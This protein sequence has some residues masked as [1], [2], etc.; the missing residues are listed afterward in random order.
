MN[1]TYFRVRNFEKLQPKR[2]G[3]NAPWI[4]LY[5]NWMLDSAVSQLGDTAKAHWIGIISVAHTESNRIPYDPV[6]IKRR[7][8]FNS[9]VKLDVFIKLGL[10]EILDNKSVSTSEQ[11][12]PIGSIGRVEEK[13]VVIQDENI[14]VSD[15]DTLIQHYRKE[16]KR[17]FKEFPDMN[18]G[19]D[20]AI[21]KGL[22]K[23]YDPV[24]VKQW[25]TTFLDSDNKFVGETGRSILVFKS[26]INK[27]ITGTLKD[28]GKGNNPNSRGEPRI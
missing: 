23:A 25:I 4:R 7:C 20:G 24:K 9:P 15:E 13:R 17:V 16:F 19:R 5:A 21:L 27:L 3:K 6:W 8:I 26:Q 28:M 14:N 18:Y 10:I 22:A 12:S 11:K 2:N 1:Q